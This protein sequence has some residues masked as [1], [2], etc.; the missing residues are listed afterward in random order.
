M[1]NQDSFAIFDEPQ[2]RTQ[3]CIAD[4]LQRCPTVTTAAELGAIIRMS[5]RETKRLL[6]IMADSPHVSPF[7]RAR[8]QTICEESDGRKTIVFK[9]R[10]YDFASASFSDDAA[11]PSLYI[12]ERELD[13]FDAQAREG[14]PQG[15]E[16]K[17]SEQVMRG[18]RSPQVTGTPSDIVA[19]AWKGT[20]LGVQRHRSA[21]DKA[22]KGWTEEEIRDVA[23]RFAADDNAR[24]RAHNQVSLFVKSVGTYRDHAKAGLP[25]GTWAVQYRRKEG[26]KGKQGK[27]DKRQTAPEV[28]EVEPT[29]IRNELKRVGAKDVPQ[30]ALWVQVMVEMLADTALQPPTDAKAWLHADGSIN[31]GITRGEYAIECGKILQAAG[32]GVTDDDGKTHDDWFRISGVLEAEFC[33]AERA[34]GY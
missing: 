18:G 7:I 34:A 24:K 14:A 21:I 31:L 12:R 3:Y 33:K 20:G 28:R 22:M 2:G 1:Q 27:Q 32:E 19:Q 29:A 13:L 10:R 9:T 17:N 23:I 4:I 15:R 30:I 8:C 5:S 16:S 11:P 25:V 26:G 6:H